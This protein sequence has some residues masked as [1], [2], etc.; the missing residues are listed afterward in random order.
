L[1]SSG[2]T[3]AGAKTQRTLTSK[4]V[5]F[6]SVPCDCGEV[7]SVS[8]SSHTGGRRRPSFCD[9]QRRLH[10]NGSAGLGSWEHYSWQG[11]YAEPVPQ[12]SPLTHPTVSGETCD[13]PPTLEPAGVAAEVAVRKATQMSPRLVCRKAGL[14]TFPLD[15]SPAAE[16]QVDVRAAGAAGRGSWEQQGGELSTSGTGWET[17]TVRRRVGGPIDGLRQAL[18]PNR[19]ERNAPDH[20]GDWAGLP[21][22][23][24]RNG[25]AW[26]LAPAGQRGLSRSAS[27]R[28]LH[29]QS[30]AEAWPEQ[31]WPAQPEAWP[32]PVAL[33]VEGILDVGHRP[34]STPAHDHRSRKWY[35]AGDNYGQALAAAEP[36]A[37]TTRQP[38]MTEQTVSNR[39]LEAS[40]SPESVVVNRRIGG[41]A[42]AAMLATL[43]RPRTPPPRL[44][45]NRHERPA[46]AA[47]AQTPPPWR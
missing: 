33:G 31:Q 12:S 37:R 47:R 9:I 16:R 8:S 21:A 26:C 30:L 20:T 14:R 36:V 40:G 23:R 29:L 5:I 3:A 10:C 13:V 38:L 45:E 15:S 25:A 17:L 28:Q 22:C 2:P 42:P 27:E 39:W 1:L 4:D 34:R 43:H 19:E 7:N 44:V 46:I 11:S 6:G 41:P 32:E 24:G 35:D 18:Q